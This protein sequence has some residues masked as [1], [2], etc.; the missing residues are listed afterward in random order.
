ML[1]CL[2]GVKFEIGGYVEVL[3]LYNMEGDE[4]EIFMKF[5]KCVKVGIVILFGDGKL[6]VIVM[7]EKEDGIWMIEFYYDGIFMEIL[8]SLGE[9][10]LL[11]YIK[12]KFDDLDC[13]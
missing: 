1:V 3:L 2:Y 5:V 9:M 11:L 7:V 6:M 12:E 8:E 4:W 13:Y 10:L